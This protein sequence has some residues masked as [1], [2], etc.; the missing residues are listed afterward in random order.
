MNVK[1]EE[2]AKEKVVEQKSEKTELSS[3][4]NNSGISIFNNVGLFQTSTP[5][6]KITIDFAAAG[7]FNSNGPNAV[8]KPQPQ[9]FSSLFSNNGFNPK[10]QEKPE[11]KLFGSATSTAATPGLFA[12][13]APASSSLFGGSG[14][15]IFSFK[16]GNIPPIKA[17]QAEDDEGDSADLDNEQKMEADPSKST[18]KYEYK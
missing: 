9:P 12:H 11:A 3:L 1:K 13:I 18:G 6:P 16:E 14:N 17:G 2:A 8:P 15:S 10:P 4:F 7:L 5:S